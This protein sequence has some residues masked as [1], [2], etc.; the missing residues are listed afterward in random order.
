MRI[1]R[2]YSED[3]KKALKMALS[4][5][6]KMM[7]DEE[8]RPYDEEGNKIEKGEHDKEEMPEEERTDLKDEEEEERWLKGVMME[9][10]KS[11]KH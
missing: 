5:I 2:A 11:K 9:L 10:R 8:E 7:E 3:E 1:K 4:I 6:S